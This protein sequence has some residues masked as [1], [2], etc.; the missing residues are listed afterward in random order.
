[1]F[2]SLPSLPTHISARE[3]G[4]SL[5]RVPLPRA[6]R[7]QRS[8]LTLSI[9]LHSLWG[10]SVRCCL[11]VWKKEIKKKAR[12]VEV[13]SQ[14]DRSLRRR[15]FSFS[16]AQALLSVHMKLFFSSFLSRL[17]LVV[18]LLLKKKSWALVSVLRKNSFMIDV[19]RWRS[20]LD[21]SISSRKTV[22]VRK[23]KNQQNRNHRDDP[24][25]VEEVVVFCSEWSTLALFSHTQ[26]PAHR[27][28]IKRSLR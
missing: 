6:K 11:S 5:Q 3:P 24:C 14:V 15:F 26:Q 16:S 8:R 9:L 27:G 10:L 17:C 19:S 1:M 2:R 23:K 21:S 28:E 20:C 18:S 13:S 22:C 12:V 25:Q 7:R 4:Q